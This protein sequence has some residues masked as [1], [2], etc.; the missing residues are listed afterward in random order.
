[1]TKEEVKQKVIGIVNELRAERGLPRMPK[2]SVTK[3]LEALGL[4]C[5]DGSDI[6][7]RLEWEY[8]CNFAGLE[9]AAQTRVKDPSQGYEQA[10]SP[11]EIINYIA[12]NGKK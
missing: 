11:R 2:V 9:Q 8:G 12:G 7:H 10:L 3:S 5:F 6:L 1:M 4:D